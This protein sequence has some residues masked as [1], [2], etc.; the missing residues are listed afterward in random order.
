MESEPGFP[1]DSSDSENDSVI[2]TGPYTCEYCSVVFRKK[3]K[4][5]R[6]L[7][8]H[9]KEVVTFTM[10]SSIE[11]ISLYLPRMRKSL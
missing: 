8:T 1:S 7:R 11:T 10:N 2:S 4:Y 5:V 6:H 3:A 9:T